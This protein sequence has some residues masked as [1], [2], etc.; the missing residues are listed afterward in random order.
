MGGGECPA[1]WIMPETSAG[2]PPDEG[3]RSDA[4]LG[5]GQRLDPFQDAEDSSGTSMK[6][7][8]LQAIIVTLILPPLVGIYVF[9]KE[10]RTNVK[11]RISKHIT[12]R[13]TKCPMATA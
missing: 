13:K 3:G 10:E 4:L 8:F 2:V 9:L 1:G 5:K 6:R 7:V 11:L 12:I